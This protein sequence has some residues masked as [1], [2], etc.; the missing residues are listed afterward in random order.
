M[1]TFNGFSAFFA[2]ILVAVNS[3]E[4][5]KGKSN[6]MFLLQKDDLFVL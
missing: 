3:Q 6:N 5:V 4:L 1:A 2:V